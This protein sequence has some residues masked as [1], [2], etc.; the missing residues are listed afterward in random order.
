MCDYVIVCLLNVDLFLLASKCAMKTS[1]DYCCVQE[2]GEQEECG[3]SKN[4]HV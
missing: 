3:D 2:P 4:V 1:Q